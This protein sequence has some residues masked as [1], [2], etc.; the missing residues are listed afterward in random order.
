LTRQA[1]QVDTII[2]GMILARVIMIALGFLAALS[3]AMLKG[4]GGNPQPWPS[5]SSRP[6]WSPTRTT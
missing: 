2:A 5:S 6:A 1:E 4:A 3:F